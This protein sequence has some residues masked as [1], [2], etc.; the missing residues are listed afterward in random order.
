LG[1]QRQRGVEQP[2]ATRRISRL[3]VGNATRLQPEE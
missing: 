3:H 1:E 2:V